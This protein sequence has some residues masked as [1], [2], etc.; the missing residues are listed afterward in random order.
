M[1]PTETVVLVELRQLP[2]TDR[3]S[4][5]YPTSQSNSPP[6]VGGRGAKRFDHVFLG[7][8]AACVHPQARDQSL[9]VSG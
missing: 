6:P 4:S 2:N 8:G 9:T 7:H 1:H 3:G 5:R